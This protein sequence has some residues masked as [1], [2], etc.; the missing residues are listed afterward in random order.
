MIVLVF[1]VLIGSLGVP[2]VGTYAGHHGSLAI[3][4]FRALEKETQ[5]FDAKRTVKMDK[6]VVI[7]TIKITI[8]V[9]I[10]VAKYDKILIYN[11]T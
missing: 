4:V 9:I 1:M 2:L 11:I 6:I 8:K 10:D 7:M 3:A 5:I